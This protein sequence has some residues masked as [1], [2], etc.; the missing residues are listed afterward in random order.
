MI[1]RLAVLLLTL[2]LGGCSLWPASEPTIERQ[3]L[4]LEADSQ[5]NG[6]AGSSHSVVVR[7][8]QLSS[9]GSFKS[10]PFL[11]LYSDDK[12]RLGDSFIALDTLAP[13]R[14][15][16]RREVNF[17][18]YPNTRFLAVLAEFSDYANARPKS[19]LRLDEDTL[20]EPLA[21]DIDGLQ[22]SLEVREQKPWWQFF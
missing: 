18:L 14:P 3:G 13:V 6:Y 20:D 15:G 11:E 12:A 22:I 7:L 5:I 9:A 16:E 2:V 21:I 4:T 19:I 17:D 10:T 1:N 8:Y